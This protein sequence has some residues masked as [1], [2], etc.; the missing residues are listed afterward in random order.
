MSRFLLWVAA[1]VAGACANLAPLPAEAA[2][3]VR[4]V[5]STRMPFELFAPEQAAGEGYFKEE[6]L[7]VDIIYA[8]GGAD[9]IQ[10]LA[11]GSQDVTVGVGTESVLT[12]F[13]KGAPLT[14]LGNGRRGT[15]EVIWYVPKDSPIKTLK[16]LEGKQLAYS[17]PGSTTHT[18][19]K[20]LLRETGIKAE[21][22]SVGA[23]PASRT[24]A[25]SGQI[26]TGWA[27][28]PVM[29]DEVRKGNIRIV[30]SG[31]DVKALADWS[32][33]VTAANSDWV[34]K[35]PDVAKRF[36]RALWK[37]VKFNYEGGER[38]FKRYADK[39]SLDLA[40]ARRGPEFT[41][42]KDVSYTPINLDG[43]MELAVEEK[44]MAAPL[45]PDQL[46]KLVNVVYD[47][48]KDK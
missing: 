32:I 41:P 13:S 1:A 48:A 38:A 39:W 21:L 36:M 30:A 23:M 9:T 24:Q 16:D 47:P 22:V 11:T 29:L 42:L 34:A 12:A 4:L 20:Y 15:S 27:A 10:A 44:M 33:R 7:D 25:M 6:N 31:A 45:K 43:V 46:K 18:I 40:D 14:I 19:G 37:G 3:K 8:S 28:A 5:I 2:D 35:N 26:A 17:R